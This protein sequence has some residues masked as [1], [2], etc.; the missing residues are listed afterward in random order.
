MSHGAALG[1][2]PGPAAALVTAAVSA[3]PVRQ[4]RARPAARTVVTSIGTLSP[5]SRLTCPVSSAIYGSPGA[6]PHAWMLVSVPLSRIWCRSRITCRRGTRSEERRVG[7]ER[8]CG[9]R[10]DYE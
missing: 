7:K 4:D 2:G 3:G 5:N 1:G 10:R 6:D 8:K 9:G